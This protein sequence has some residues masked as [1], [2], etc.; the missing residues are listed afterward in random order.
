MASIDE[1]NGVVVGFEVKETNQRTKSDYRPGYYRLNSFSFADAGISLNHASGFSS[2]PI[3]SS[4]IGGSMAAFTV[5]GDYLYAIDGSDILSFELSDLDL[6]K[7]ISTGYTLETIFPT[8]DMLFL[9]TTTGML[10]YG[11]DDPKAPNFISVFEHVE[12]CDPVVVEGNYAYVTLRTGTRCWGN[13]NQLDVLDISDINNPTLITS[14]GLN[15]PHGLGIDGNT[16]FIC[17][18]DAGLK[19]YTVDHDNN[20]SLTFRYGYEGIRATDVIPLKHSKTL[21]MVSDEGI[22]QYDYSDLSS[23]SL[24]ST[25]N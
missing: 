2:S 9:G 22:F 21:I 11:L 4:G 3:S 6:K 16:L 17:D 14:K 15:N 1:S 25:I 24:L 10:I 20:S 7:T 5:S 23:V 19:I 18:G 13:S 12:S 8:N